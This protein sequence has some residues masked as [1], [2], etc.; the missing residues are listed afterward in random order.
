MQHSPFQ[1]Q[2]IFPS[3]LPSIPLKKAPFSLKWTVFLF[4]E[5][6]ITIQPKPIFPPSLEFEPLLHNLYTLRTSRYCLDMSL[7]F[8]EVHNFFLSLPLRL[9]MSWNAS[10]G[11]KR[12]DFSPT[13][14]WSV[15]ELPAT[16]R[17]NSAS[18]G[19]IT[20]RR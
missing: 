20:S 10:R 13:S 6:R 18:S 11:W 9:R 14:G 2:H 1:P 3:N 7:F 19:A 15:N 4:I 16:W 8:S 5:H 17:R 12:I